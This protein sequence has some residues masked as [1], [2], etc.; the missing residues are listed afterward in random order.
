MKVTF[1][2]DERI[3]E[4]AGKVAAAKGKSLND[5]VCEHLRQLAGLDTL[6]QRVDA[7][8]EA[9]DR[10]TGRLDGWKFDREEANRRV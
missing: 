2:V 8:T 3:V 9:S 5:V 1:D 6:Q 10:T 7:F 4:E